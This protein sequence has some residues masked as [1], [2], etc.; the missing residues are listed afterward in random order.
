DRLLGNRQ[1]SVILMN[2]ETGEIIVMASHPAFDPNELDENGEVLVRDENAPLLNRA[3]QGLYP[4]GAASLPLFMA[5]FGEDQP[6]AMERNQLYERLGFFEAP[7]INMPVSFDA[8]GNADSLRLSPLQVALAAA[9]LSNHG[10]APAP[11]IATAVNTREQ[12]WVVLPA[13]GR[14][15]K[16]LEPQAADEAAVSFIQEGMPY[17]SYLARAEGDEEPVAWLLAGTLPPWRGTPL[18]L[19]VALEENNIHLAEIIGERLLDVALS[20]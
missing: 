10:V 19:V 13:L 8:Q 12:G 18:A 5:E 11:R 15:R 20:Q 14:S 7:A 6:S 4:I 3:T 17:W 2:A 9:V 1:G 16:V